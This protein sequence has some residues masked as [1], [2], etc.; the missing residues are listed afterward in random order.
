VAAHPAGIAGVFDRAADSYDD[1]GV[2]WFGPIAQGLVEELDVRAGERVLDL[3]CGRGAAL[4]PLARAAGS[5]GRALGLDLAPRMV[6]R[7]AR[8]ARDLPQLEVRVGDA[9]AP[10]VEQQAYDVVSC[11]LVLFFL[12]DPAAAVR[13]WVPALAP[14]GT[15]RRPPATGCPA[16]RRS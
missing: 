3:G 9:C 11:C 1:V 2:P 7:T 12:P 5:T 6:E 8:D 16:A 15:P 10:D 14:G 13:A 4:P